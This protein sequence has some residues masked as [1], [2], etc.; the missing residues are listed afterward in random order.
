MQTSNVLVIGGAGFIGSHLV[1]R[2][3]GAASASG[4]PL[5]PGA[6]PI[7]RSPRIASSSARA[8]SST[9]STCCCCRA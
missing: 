3:A 8:I 1:S 6:T 9:R 7:P 2:L 5:E 4:A